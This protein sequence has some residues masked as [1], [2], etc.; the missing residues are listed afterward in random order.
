MGCPWT[1]AV[2]VGMSL[3]PLADATPRGL[4]I[5]SVWLQDLETEIR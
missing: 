3:I 2:G 4:S 5:S 1:W